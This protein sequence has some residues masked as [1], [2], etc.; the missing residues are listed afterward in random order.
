MAGRFRRRRPTTF[1]A[2]CY[3]KPESIAALRSGQ[4]EAYAANMALQWRTFAWCVLFQCLELY[5]L[6]RH[7]RI[8]DDGLSEVLGELDLNEANLG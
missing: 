3:Q 8:S 5:S 7:H 1:V 6:S 2:L 4:L